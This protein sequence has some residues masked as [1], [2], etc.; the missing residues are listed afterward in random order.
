MSLLMAGVLQCV[1]P[2]AAVW[3]QSGWHYQN[4]KSLKNKKEEKKKGE[5][6]LSCCY[7]RRHTIFS[8]PLNQKLPGAVTFCTCQGHISL[9][10]LQIIPKTAEKR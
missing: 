10:V 3:K 5:N 9:A 6:E 8:T 2:T 4:R 7:T 1:L